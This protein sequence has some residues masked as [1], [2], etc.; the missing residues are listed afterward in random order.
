MTS[1]AL[2]L[3]VAAGAAAQ[4][5][6]TIAPNGSVAFT[7]TAVVESLLSLGIAAS[8]G[9]VLA[10]RPRRPGAP[11][12]LPHVIQTQIMLAIVGSLV[13]MVVGASLARAFGIAGAASLVRYRAKVDDP[14]DAS[15]MLSCLALGLASGVGLYALAAAGA[16]FIVAVLWALEWREPSPVKAFELK[17]AAREPAALKSALEALLKQHH[18][19]YELRGSTEKDVSYA[20]EVPRNGRTDRISEAIVRLGGQDAVSVEWDAKKAK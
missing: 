18:I 7:T 20:V 10:F 6:E 16:A 3:L 8:L 11:P 14:K 5:P 17:V 9:A 13:M 15:V 1:A 19:K 12:R 2:L 4:A